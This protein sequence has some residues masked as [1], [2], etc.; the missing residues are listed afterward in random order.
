MTVVLVLLILT[1]EDAVSSHDAP[2]ML[3]RSKLDLPLVSMQSSSVGK[4]AV[5]L[6]C[7][8]I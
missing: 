5:I 7:M 8:Y 4:T 1:T 6:L 3:N 2:E